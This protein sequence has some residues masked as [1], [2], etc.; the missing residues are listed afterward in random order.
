MRID[1]WSR[2]IARQEYVAWLTLRADHGALQGTLQG[3]HSD[4]VIR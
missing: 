2:A 1:F 3:V 4:A